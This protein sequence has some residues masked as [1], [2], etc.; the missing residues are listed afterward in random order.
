VTDWSETESAQF[1]DLGD[2]AV[3]RRD[4]MLAALVAAA[5]FAHDRPIRI[6]EL[7]CGDGS[8]AA[9][10]LE[11]FGKATLV[12]LDGSERMRQTTAA[13]L[14][15]F[16]SRAS[17][18]AFELA[19]LDWWDRLNGVDLVTSS[20]CL[21]HLNDAKKQYLYK[22]IASRITAAGALLIAD[23]IEMQ[24]PSTLK[25][26]A[27]AW[28]K[29]AESQA[30]EHGRPDAFDRFVRAGWNHFRSPDPVDQ[31][32]AL[33]HH[34]VWLKHAGFAVVDC[35]WLFA[36]HAVLGAFKQPPG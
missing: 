32:A 4:E 7:G 14:A 13:R 26:S 2:V 25:A 5:P 28:D 35:W 31:P 15:S 34:L 19:A 29:A 12:G 3:P 10:M 21:H 6:L 22:A 1:Q 9:R 20:L 8:L 17:V 16:G 23:L 27:D 11:A 33:L 30:R 18:A 24:H 36:G